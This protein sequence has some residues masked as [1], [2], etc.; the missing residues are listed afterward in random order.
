MKQIQ[1]PKAK[2]PRVMLRVVK[3]AFVPADNAS[4]QEQLAAR[5]ERLGNAA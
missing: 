3:G 4:T 2:R 5:I 1:P